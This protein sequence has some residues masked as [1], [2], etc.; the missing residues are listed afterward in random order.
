MTIRKYDEEHAAI[1]AAEKPEIL[2]RLR[3]VKSAR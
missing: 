3:R 2:S 1:L